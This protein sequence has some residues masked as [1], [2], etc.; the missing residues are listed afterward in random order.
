M[1]NLIPTSL[2][3][4]NQTLEIHSR[5]LDTAIWLVPPNAAERNF[6]A[7]IYGLAECKL[8]LC[9]KAA[10]ETFFATHLLKAVLQHGDLIR[11]LSSKYLNELRD[12]LLED[13]NKATWKLAYRPEEASKKKRL[14][15]AR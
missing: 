14:Q 1:S 9:L 15:I 13:H 10:T 11:S 7:P 8:L 12:V 2:Y 4:L 6:D 3:L 5:L